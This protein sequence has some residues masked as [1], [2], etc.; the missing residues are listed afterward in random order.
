MNCPLYYWP[1]FLL[2]RLKVNSNDCPPSDPTKSS[3]LGTRLLHL[4]H[5]NVVPVT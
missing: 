4:T 2:Y 1:D 3:N 5:V